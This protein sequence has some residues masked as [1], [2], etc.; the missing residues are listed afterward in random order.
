MERE[1][2]SREREWLH[3]RL[4]GQGESIGRSLHDYDGTPQHGGSRR[5]IPRDRPRA[6]DLLDDEYRH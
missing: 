2:D 1:R 5:D 4:V 3:L 6:A